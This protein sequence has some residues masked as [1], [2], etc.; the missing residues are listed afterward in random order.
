L[1]DTRTIDPPFVLPPVQWSDGIAKHTLENVGL[2]DLFVIG[3][4][5]KD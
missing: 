4:E 3:V 2:D 1:V 5:L